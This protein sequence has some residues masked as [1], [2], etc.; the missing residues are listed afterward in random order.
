MTDTTAFRFRF[1]RLATT[2]GL[3]LATMGCGPDFP[4]L[5][6]E[7]QRALLQ[8]NYAA[9]R[10]R[11][12]G[13]YA[14]RPED[15][16][17]L[18]DLGSVCIV[19]ARQW[20]AEQ[21]A[22]AA[23]REVDQAVEYFGRAVEAHPGMQ[24]ALVARNEALELKGSYDEALREAEWAMA[25]VGPSARTQLFMADELEERGDVDGALL[26]YRQAVAMEPDNA[27]AHAAFGRFLRRIGKQEA[28]LTHLKRAYKINPLEPGVAEM[29]TDQGV[30]LPRT[31]EPLQP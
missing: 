5:R 28:A 3:C 24:A 7:G 20:A 15:A 17:N 30:A 18:F 21:N 19:Y 31:T 1:T 25:F 13:A 16:E 6:L 11:F 27:G 2:L 23:M 9:A 22:P 8:E 26:R 14:I 29:L 12:E 4:Q 10:G